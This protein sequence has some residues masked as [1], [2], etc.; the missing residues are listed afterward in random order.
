MLFD[1]TSPSYL[2]TFGGKKCLS[3]KVICAFFCPAY[4]SS[5]VPTKPTAA[6]KY[7]HN[8]I[9]SFH[10]RSGTILA[11]ILGYRRISISGTV[12]SG[13]KP[14]RGRCFLCVLT[15][16]TGRV[17][18]CLAGLSCKQELYACSYFLPLIE[19]RLYIKGAA[20]LTCEK[21]MCRGSI[22]QWTCHTVIFSRSM[23]SCKRVI[24]PA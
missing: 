15:R 16:S 21:A 4:R 1:L 18:N 17:C 23:F 12:L 10:F 7:H 14:M 8:H 13:R 3:G 6:S 19:V 24:L 2:T 5:S 11:Q 9:I 20:Y 22:S